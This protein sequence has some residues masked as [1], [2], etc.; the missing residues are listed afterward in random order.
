M[1]TLST[2]SAG[3]Q[4]AG[5]TVLRLQANRIVRW[6][7][8]KRDSLRRWKLSRWVGTR[9]GSEV[10]GELSAAEPDQAW[11]RAR[12]FGGDRAFDEL[13]R[14]ARASRLKRHRNSRASWHRGWPAFSHEHLS[15]QSVLRPRPRLA[16]VMAE[17]DYNT[18]PF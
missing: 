1:D 11:D 17:A 10:I 5:C 16:F 6:A 7:K 4:G 2:T 15:T 13:Q 3:A 9:R 12:W 14:R 8:S 18:L